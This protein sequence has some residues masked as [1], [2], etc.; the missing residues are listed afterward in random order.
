MTEKT[1]KEQ[2][3]DSEENK[4]LTDVIRA[5]LKADIKRRESTAYAI[6]AG[7]DANP[8]PIGRRAVHAFANDYEIT[9]NAHKWLMYIFFEDQ[10]AQDENPQN[11]QN[12]QNPTK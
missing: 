3:N 2:L 5:K 11:P 10:E 1:I 7:I 12:P 4:R 8:Y 6:R 9:S